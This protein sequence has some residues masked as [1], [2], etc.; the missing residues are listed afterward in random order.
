MICLSAP[1]CLR[2]L[3]NENLQHE[4]STGMPPRSTSCT[5]DVVRKWKHTGKDWVGV[6]PRPSHIGYPPAASP[7]ANVLLNPSR[8]RLYFVSDLN[9]KNARIQSVFSG[10]KPVSKT[11][12]SL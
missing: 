1:P 2:Y 6:I 9:P 8:M 5:R 11:I 7:N 3:R 10:L 12:E 4:N